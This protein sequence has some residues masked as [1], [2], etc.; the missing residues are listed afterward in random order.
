VL[1]SETEIFGYDFLDRVTSVSGPYAQSFTYNHI[2]NINS[3]NGTSYTYG[4]SS[5]KHAV[6][7]A[8][9]TSYAYDANGNMTTR[10]T[11]TITWDVENRP[12]TVTG[13]ASFV[14]D[15]DGNRVKSRFIKIIRD[16]ESRDS[17]KTEN[18]E[19]ILY[20]NK[21]YEKNLTTGVVTTNYYWRQAYSHP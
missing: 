8:G 11:Q 18:G 20:V 6:T 1:V 5:H 12:L 15:G 7:A 17:Q 16:F 2:G 9:S 19:T 14:Y 13:G 3:M 4:S 21:Y 10:G